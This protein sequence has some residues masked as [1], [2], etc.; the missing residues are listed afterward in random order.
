[1]TRATSGARPGVTRSGVKVET[2]TWSTSAP[3]R[4]ASSSASRQARVGQVGERLVALEVAALA[5]AG[6]AHD[7]LV[8]G[9]QALLEV[10]VGDDVARAARRRCRRG[11]RSCRAGAGAPGAGRWRLW[12]CARRWPPC[13]RSRL[14]GSLDEAGEDR[15]GAE[16]DE[17]LDAARRAAP[18][19]SRASARGAAGSRPAR[20][21]RRRRARRCRWS[22][23]GCV[24]S[25]TG[26]ASSAARR[27]SA[28]GSM[29]GEWKA[30]VT[31][32]RRARA[33]ASSRATSSA[34]SSASTAPRARAGRGR[35]RW[36]P[37][38]PGARRARARSRPSP[39]S[40]A[41]MPPALRSPASAIA[42][43][44]SSTRR[45]GVLELQRAGGD[46]RGVLAERVAGGGARLG[47]LVGLLAPRRPTRR[48]STGRARAA[49]S[50][51]P[52]Q[53]CSKGS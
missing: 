49:G 44:R 42:A 33:P 16:L 28:A 5:D 35:C 9:V 25:A 11:R 52:R 1:M 19:A 6:A 45:D 26:V 29:S 43:A 17:A 40:I 20:G 14:Q 37:R 15:A 50:G 47:L 18:A 31:S 22:R 53:S 7:P 34:S 46:Q 36:R 38:G 51:C 10:V 48:P 27:R 3:V 21:A 32:R 12:A 8:V 24:G 13:S 41:T 39:P 2:M 4:P 23:R 30:P